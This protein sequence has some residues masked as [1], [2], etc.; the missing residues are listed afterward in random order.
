M[1]KLLFLVCLLCLMPST[2]H[3]E[4]IDV[5]VYAN[6]RT[7]AQGELYKH[8]SGK[9]LDFGALGE[10]VKNYYVVA[11][12]AGKVLAHCRVER[13]AQLLRIRNYIDAHPELGIRYWATYRA[14]WLDNTTL[15]KAVAARTLRYPVQKTDSQGT[16]YTASVTVKEARDA[17]ITINPLLVQLPHQWAGCNSEAQ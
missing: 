12:E 11:T 8:W 2:S 3:A 1:K 9:I 10:V 14:L 5:L 4:D 16:T 13:S 6:L 7:L 15:G 17:G